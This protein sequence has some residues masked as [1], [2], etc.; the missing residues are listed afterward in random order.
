LVCSDRGPT[1]SELNRIEAGRS[2]GWPAMEGSLCT[3]TGQLCLDPRY[4]RPHSSYRHF[5]GQCGIVGGVFHASADPALLE[6]VIT[7]GDACSG[8]LAGA[9][10]RGPQSGKRGQMGV[11]AGGVRAL[12][13]DAEGRLLAIAED[14]ALFKLAL[15]PDGVPGT[16]PKRLSETGCYADLEQAQLVDGLLEFRVRSPLWS[17]A[18]HNRRFLFVPDGARIEAPPT[19]AW[20]F[21]VGTI[22]VKQFALQFDDRDPNSVRPIET[23]FILHQP[24][25]WEFHSY[26][27]NAEGTDAELVTKEETVAYTLAAQGASH[28]QEYQFPGPN[29]CPICHAVAP[30]RVLGP[31]TEQ[32]N[33]PVRYAEGAEPRNQLEALAALGLFDMPEGE[34]PSLPDPS[35]SALPLEQ[36]ARSY[37]HAN[38][39]HCHQPEGWSSPGFTM[40]LRYG[41][42]LRDAHICGEEPMFFREGRALIAPGA[43]DESAILIRMRDLDLDRMPPVATQ[44]VDPSGAQV[45]EDWIRSLSGCP[46]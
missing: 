40:D 1:Q 34:L 12:G 37:L 38:C 24:G 16:F 20:A 28:V 32:L 3:D 13:S 33:Y 15:A 29:T 17:D 4:E 7:H 25:G 30:G 6:G 5:E 42:T 14:G 35:D 41:L 2:Y 45:V 9:A 46:L 11:L 43:P 8:V 23:R 19:G 22:L 10:L 27:W 26:R 44:V 31:R 18:T 36:R 21:P 39:A